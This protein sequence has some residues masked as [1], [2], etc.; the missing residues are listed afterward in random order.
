MTQGEQTRTLR[1][2]FDAAGVGWALREG[3]D[4]EAERF[5]QE[6][7]AVEAEYARRLSEPMSSPLL[8]QLVEEREAL[9][10]LIQAFA[11][12]T[13]VPI[14]VMIYCILKG[15]EILRVRYDYERKHRSHLAID[16]EL[17]GGQTL[18]FESEDLW[19]TEVLRHFGMAKRGGRP[20]LDGYYAFR[21]S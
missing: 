19:D 13:S 5:L 7:Q 17:P 8:D 10:P 21:R 2:L 16:I 1:Q 6:M 18:S 12:P 15:A 14:R 4:A 11:S 20:I 9:T 3:A